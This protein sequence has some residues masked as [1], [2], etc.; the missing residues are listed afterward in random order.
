MKVEYNNEYTDYARDSF[1]IFSRLFFRS[2]LFFS[3]IDR[4]FANIIPL[5]RD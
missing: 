3:R 2:F 1:V 5:N 4:I